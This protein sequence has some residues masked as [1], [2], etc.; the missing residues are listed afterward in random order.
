MEVNYEPKNKSGKDPQPFKIE[1]QN[2]KQ[3]YDFTPGTLISKLNEIEGIKEKFH[4][5]ECFKLFRKQ[6][7]FC[8]Q[9][10]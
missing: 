7:S 4:T 9:F 5:L 10:L 2:I 8:R 6:N 1:R 3:Y